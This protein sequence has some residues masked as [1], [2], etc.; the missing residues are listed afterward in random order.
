MAHA[1]LLDI[2]A[3]A[4]LE[5]ARFNAQRTCASPE[6]EI[7]LG[8]GGHLRWLTDRSRPGNAYYNRAIAERAGDLPTK[9]IAEMPSTVVSFELRPSETQPG[10]ADALLASNFRPAAT[11]CYLAMRPPPQRLEASHPVERLP[12]S[13]TDFFFDL[14]E[15]AGTPFPPERRAS[16][17]RFY[18]TDEFQAFVV[19]D[20]SGSPLG[21]STL[22]RARNFAFLGN[23]YTRPE[24]RCR[25]VHAALLAARL[26]AAIGDGVD[27]IFTDVEHGS[28]SHSNCERA[29]FRTVTV[30]TLWERRA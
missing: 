15:S 25:G 8:A 17:R 14:L 19:V 2:L 3:G 16:K 12:H 9:A 4:E 29:G 11:L 28:Q 23:S 27:H 18:C 21:W 24:V 7:G 5:F 22:F 1:D 20:D 30:N 10:I 13:R 26:N 6:A